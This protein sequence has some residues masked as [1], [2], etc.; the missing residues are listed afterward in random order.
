MVVDSMK[1]KIYI[2]LLSVLA[3]CAALEEVSC[4][5]KEEKQSVSN[6]HNNL[7]T[8]PR[9]KTECLS[10]GEEY[11]INSNEETSKS[12]K[13]SSEM[14]WLQYEKLLETHIAYFGFL[15]FVLSTYL[16]VMGVCLKTVC[17]NM[18]KIS[19]KKEGAKTLLL[20]LVAFAVVASIIFMIGLY[21][22]KEDAA[23]R[24][25]Q[26]KRIA[27]FL[28]RFGIEELVNVKLLEDLFR[29][30][31][32][33][34]MVIISIWIIILIRITMIVYKW[35]KPHWWL[36][37]P[38]LLIIGGGIVSYVLLLLS[39]CICLKEI[40]YWI[41]SAS[42]VVASVGILVLFII[43]IAGSIRFSKKQIV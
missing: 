31:V 6:S 20:S 5:V 35:E 15:L 40:C 7:R 32:V 9:D 25:N 27:G 36:V 18:D 17:A 23:Q 39:D 41:L 1:V 16:A 13:T 42:G 24:T 38:T 12:K 10:A 21:L 26:V 2:I 8:I 33:G 28:N 37:I 30:I 4:V 19:D 43:G 14:Y 3:F 34:P 11:S 22:G 29:W